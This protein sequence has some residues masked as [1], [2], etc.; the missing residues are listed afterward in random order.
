MGYF[1]Q[2]LTTQPRWIHD[3]AKAEMYSTETE[4]LLSHSNSLDPKQLVEEDTIHFLNAL[5]EQLNEFIRIFNSHSAQNSKFQEVKIYTLGQSAADF[6]LFRNQI[7][8]IFSNVSPGIIQASFSQHIHSAL[9]IDGQSENP[10]IS[11]TP[12]HWETTDLL[13]QIGPFREVYWTFQG[14]KILPEQVAKFY[15]IEFTKM[16]RTIKPSSDGNQILLKQ[17][18]AFLQKKGLDL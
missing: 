9:H 16:S 5:R 14:D 13:A 8:L 17:I 10:P 18:K 1:Y 6:M 2:T 12:T 15:F 11:N 4:T 3:L 7:K